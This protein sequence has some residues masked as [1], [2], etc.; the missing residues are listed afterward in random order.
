MT[1]QTHNGIIYSWLIPDVA[2]RYGFSESHA[3][4]L[5][6]KGIIP[7]LKVGRR[8]YFNPQAVD[9]ALVRINNLPPRT[10]YSIRETLSDEYT[11]DE[12]DIDDLEGL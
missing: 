6:A 5:A 8:Y 1:V 10:M 2:E 9:D 3:R 12:F 7:S 11:P 4:S